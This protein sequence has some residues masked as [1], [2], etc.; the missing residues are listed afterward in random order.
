MRS[1]HLRCVQTFSVGLSSCLSTVLF[2]RHARFKQQQEPKDPRVPSRLSH[3]RAG[4]GSA[5]AGG[6]GELLLP[7]PCELRQQRGGGDVASAGKSV[8]VRVGPGRDPPGCVATRISIHTQPEPAQI[9]EKRGTWHGGRSTE[10]PAPAPCAAQ[11]H[12]IAQPRRVERG[13]SLTGWL[14]DPPLRTDTGRTDPNTR[15]HGK[16]NANTCYL[17]AS[18][19]RLTLPRGDLLTQRTLGW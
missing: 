5:G 11:A 9:S 10:A 3:R 14:E 2:L 17:E 15:R 16:D 19:H 8:V 1:G 13:L 4:P 18:T 6:C 7:H 12:A